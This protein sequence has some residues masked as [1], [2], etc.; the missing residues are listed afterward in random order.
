MPSL[1]PSPAARPLPGHPK[2]PLRVGA[3]V[4]SSTICPA[5][6]E[7]F[8]TGLRAA[9]RYP[10]QGRTAPAHEILIEPIGSGGVATA[11]RLNKLVLSH[12]PDV[13]VSMMGAGTIGFNDVELAGCGRPI[14]NATLGADV[15]TAALA[16]PNI[17]TLSASTWQSALAAGE[18]AARHDRS[19][20]ALVTSLFDCGFDAFFAMR[21]GFENAGGKIVSAIVLD[22]PRAPCHPAEALAKAVAAGADTLLVMLSG[23]QAEGFIRAWA[24]SPH[25][26]SLALIGTAFLT[27][28]P[29]LQ[30]LG[31]N[32]CGV[33][34]VAAW[35]DDLVFPATEAFEA[36]YAELSDG[37]AVDLFAVLGWEAGHLLLDGMAAVPEP[38]KH[39]LDFTAAV[40]GWNFESPRGLVSMHPAS[41]TA[42]GPLYLREARPGTGHVVLEKLPDIA[43]DDA[44]MAAIHEAALSS[45]WANEYLCI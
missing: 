40:S 18:W 32:A 17:V 23:I 28:A 31:E 37:C 4:P 27:E 14:I 19:R 44:R 1:P 25:R 8:L 20:A 13:I 30:A 3:L 15:Q 26:Q 12:R 5:M 33:P 7:S 24:A 29:R 36:A 45:G 22:A 35:S 41:R 38:G 11:G 2:R 10:A 43:P 16:L 34:T 21:Q 42:S 6:G 39:P 9:L